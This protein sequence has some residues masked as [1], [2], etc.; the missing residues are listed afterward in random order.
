LLDDWSNRHAWS[1]PFGIVEKE[2]ENKREQN[3]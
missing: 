2:V 1:T 3:G